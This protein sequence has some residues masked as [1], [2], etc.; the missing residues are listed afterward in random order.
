MLG[1]LVI[2]DWTSFGWTGK[3]RQA[4]GSPKRYLMVICRAFLKQQA[5]HF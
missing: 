4:K 3:G 1:T 2:F 5:S